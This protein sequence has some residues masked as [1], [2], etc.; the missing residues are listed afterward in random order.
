MGDQKVAVQRTRGNA[1]SVQSAEM[2]PAFAPTIHRPSSQGDSSLLQ[3]GAIF[4]IY[5]LEGLYAIFAVL[6]VWSHRD[7]Q[8]CLQGLARDQIY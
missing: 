5:K 3:P 4:P 8:C 2:P 7:H 6:L 1:A